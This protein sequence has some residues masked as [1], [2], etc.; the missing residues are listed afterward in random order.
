MIGY[1]PLNAAVVSADF[2]RCRIGVE[3]GL[4]RKDRLAGMGDRRLWHL[5][6]C[7]RQPHAFADRLK[8][9]LAS[10]D[11]ALPKA[12]VKRLDGLVTHAIIEGRPE[13]ILG[14]L[15]QTATELGWTQLQR[16][17]FLS[18]VMPDAPI[19]IWAA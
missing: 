3:R 5:G 12:T 16:I 6:H 9:Q 1:A 18:K 7:Q 17:A 2:V 14:P 15:D 10:K 13:I 8:R 11:L 19:L 4:E